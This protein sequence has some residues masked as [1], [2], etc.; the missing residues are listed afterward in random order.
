MSSPDRKA[1]LAPEYPALSM[2]R[3]C[4]MLGIARSG[5][6]RLP[7][8]S[9]DM[10]LDL[11]RRI[12]ALFTQWPFLGSRRVTTLL[13]ADGHTINRKRIRR[14]M[15]RMGIAALAPKPR[16]TK[17][18]LGHEVFP[19]LLRGIAIDRPNQVWC[20]DITYIPIGRGFLYLVAIM[21]WY[22][23]TVLAWQLSNTMD[24]SFCVTA[25]EQALARFGKPEIF[26]T[27]Q[28][29]QFTSSEFIGLLT[30]ADVRISM[31]GRGRWMDNIFIER[32]ALAQ[33]RRGLSER[34]CRHRRSP[35]RDRQL[36]Q[37]LQSQTPTSG[38]A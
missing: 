17:P 3:Q 11:M 20:A 7:R 6:Y 14:L 29:S 28:G 33:I 13:R 19:Y 26:N 25:L 24:A 2:R 22:S 30:A 35:V 1:L 23:R 4:T 18:T 27:D 34:L 36:D 10:D 38:A 15:R 31:D 5:V 21:D 37:F 16:T 32:L 12:D 9:N 8:P